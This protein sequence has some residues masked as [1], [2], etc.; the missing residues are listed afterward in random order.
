MIAAPACAGPGIDLNAN[1]ICPGVAGS[2]SDGGDLDCAALATAGK[3]VSIYSTFF[4]AENISDL[5][6]LDGTVHVTI[7]PG[8]WSTTGA[9]WDGTSGACLD[10]HGG[11]VKFIGSKPVNGD[12]CGTS[13]SIRECFPD[14]SAQTTVKN[15]NNNMDMFYTV[16]KAGS[17]SV[18]TCTISGTI[19]RVVKMSWGG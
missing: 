1:H 12:P 15:D 2:S 19:T 18:T 7:G 11:A 14:G 13:L 8:D 17:Q 5:S 16:Y 3:L 4:T 10:A 9:F 6:N